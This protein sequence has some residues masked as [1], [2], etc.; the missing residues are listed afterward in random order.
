[1][2][3]LVL[4]YWDRQ[5]VADRA[6]VRLAALYAGLDLEVIVVD[7]GNAVPYVPPSGMPFPVEVVRLPLKDGPLNSSVP[8]NRGVAAASGE[9]IAISGPE[10]LHW[11]P[12]LLAL[13]EEIAGAPTTYAC[14]A[15]WH[16]EG[17]T[18]HAHSS[19]TG[20]IVH[21]IQLPA[22]AHY[23]FLA[24]LHRSLWDAAGGID[25]DYRDGIGYEDADFLLRLER[26][27]ARFV[28]RDDLIVEHVRTGARTAWPKA[29]RGLNM[30]IFM[31]KWGGR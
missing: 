3:S 2:I 1:M 17:K 6:F 20:R 11:G 29:M 9:F 31:R 5:A 25:E 19:M 30:G 7:D 8:I 21:G 13:R 22:N 10:M 16:P 24:M 27:G 15:A 18:W 4:P 12:H 26:A 28:M 23:Y 14:C